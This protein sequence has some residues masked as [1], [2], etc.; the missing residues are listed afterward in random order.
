MTAI[1]TIINPD[2]INKQLYL[3][4]MV[5]HK[6]SWQ[7]IPVPALY[8]VPIYLYLCFP[9]QWFRIKETIQIFLELIT[10]I[11]LSVL[12]RCLLESSS[13]LRVISVGFRSKNQTLVLHNHLY[14]KTKNGHH[15][16]LIPIRNITIRRSDLF[17]P[18][19]TFLNKYQVRRAQTPTLGRRE[20]LLL[21]FVIL[22]T[23]LL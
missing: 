4:K 2:K 13:T 8:L 16:H 14:V 6:N 17:A 11:F 7:N 5:F 3:G 18:S 10:G 19:K 20:K 21:I 23:L 22:K 15:L 1:E 12:H 9:K